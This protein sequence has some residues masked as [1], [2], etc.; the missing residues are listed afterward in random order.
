MRLGFGEY[1]QGLRLTVLGSQPMVVDSKENTYEEVGSMDRVRGEWL[2][3]VDV[4][5]YGE[6]WPL[7]NDKKV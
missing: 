7:M 2:R 1:Q 5:C 4:S 6:S 3:A